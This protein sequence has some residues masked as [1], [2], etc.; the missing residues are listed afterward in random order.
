MI[1][2]LVSKESQFSIMFL[3]LVFCCCN[4]LISWTETRLWKLCPIYMTNINW[5]FKFKLTRYSVSLLSTRW[6]SRLALLNTTLRSG[7]LLLVSICLLLQQCCFLKHLLEFWFPTLTR[8]LLETTIKYFYYCWKK[9]NLILIHYRV[10]K[11]ISSLSV[12]F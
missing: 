3:L 2:L 4:Y 1:L 5:S 7:S 10:L 8:L 6:K 11:L 9:N 12:A